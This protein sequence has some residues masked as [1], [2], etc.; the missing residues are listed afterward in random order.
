[1][2]SPRT[3]VGASTETAEKKESAAG[4]VFGCLG[5]LLIVAATVVLPFFVVPRDWRWATL[6][7]I[8]AAVIGVGS[9]TV[10]AKW[11]GKLLTLLLFAVPLI[12][13]A[14]LLWRQDTRIYGVAGVAIVLATLP[15]IATA[16]METP[17]AA[18]TSPPPA[19]PA[20]PPW[21][22]GRR[23][24][25]SIFVGIAIAAT[26]LSFLGF[27]QHRRA[28]YVIAY[29]QPVT[30]N[31]GSQ[32]NVIMNGGLRETKCGDVSWSINGK[33]Q[34]GTVHAGETEIGP[35]FRRTTIEAYALPGSNKA[36]TVKH[37]TADAS[38]MEFYG[39]IPW[40]TFAPFVALAI[41]VAL[42]AEPRRTKGPAG[43]P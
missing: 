31:L 1:M 25:T 15:F 12:A 27:N 18:P 34:R 16:L 32:C 11:W 30:V 23:V 3:P 2:S 14:V 22:K 24:V 9:A 35:A 39:Q 20:P 33:T 38:G 8:V 26:A 5:S 37:H 42:L 29:G 36:Y 41:C 21:P 43:R 6:S 17:S 13:G 10:A 7:G 40:W 4:T 19:A 28:A